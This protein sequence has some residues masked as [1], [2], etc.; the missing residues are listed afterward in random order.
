MTKE[1]HKLYRCS[2]LKWANMLYVDA[3]QFRMHMAKEAMRYY[4]ELASEIDDKI[5][6]ERY[7]EL[8]KLHDDSEDAYEWNE[9]FLLEIAR[10]KDAE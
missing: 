6:S 5:N 7:Q 4:E 2:P 10:K 1:T 3:L 8:I 9:K